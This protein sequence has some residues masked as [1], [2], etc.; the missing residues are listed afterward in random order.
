MNTVLDHRLRLFTGYQLR[1]VTSAAMPGVNK[2]LGLS[3]L[4]RSTFASLAVIVDTPGLN[5]GQLADAL[6]IERPNLVRIVDEL[7]DRGLIQ[8]CKSPN[9]R[10]AYALRAT[11]EGRK[12]L[13]RASAALRRFELSLVNGLSPKEI[14]ALHNALQQ[15]EKNA[16]EMEDV[17]HVEIQNP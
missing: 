11:Q 14:E 6:A 7:E 8:R 2:A 16:V 10:R 17:V 12:V 5:Q 13:S 3:G 9:D 4:R 1:R 15:I